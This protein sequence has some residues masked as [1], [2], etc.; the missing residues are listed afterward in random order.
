MTADPYRI[1]RFNYEDNHEQNYSSL[2]VSLSNQSLNNNH[3]KNTSPSH[4]NNNIFSELKNS[5][6]NNK[7][8]FV[9]AHYEANK[10]LANQLKANCVLLHKGAK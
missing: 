5:D 7:Q 3:S 8:S 6:L 10:E 2:P 9:Q 1:K 4:N